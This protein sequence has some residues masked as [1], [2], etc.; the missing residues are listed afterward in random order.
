MNP[1]PRQRAYSD[2]E[3]N[4]NEMAPQRGATGQ[5]TS[6]KLQSYCS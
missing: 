1:C 2:K 5:A 6:L 4:M 3:I